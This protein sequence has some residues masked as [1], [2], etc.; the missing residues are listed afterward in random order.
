MTA[1][2]KRPPHPLS[3]RALCRAPDPSRAADVCRPPEFWLK[4]PMAIG[5]FIYQSS[6]QRVGLRRSYTGRD[7]PEEAGK[8]W[9]ETAIPVLSTEGPQGSRPTTPPVSLALLCGWCSFA[10]RQHALH[11]S[12]VTPTRR[13]RL[14]RVGRGSTALL[15]LGGALDDGPRQGKIAA[16]HTTCR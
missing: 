2:R 15:P 9:S 16:A 8:T 1:E 3:R 14:C 6:P 4:R 11:R 13:W 12:R 7:C 5:S 10:A